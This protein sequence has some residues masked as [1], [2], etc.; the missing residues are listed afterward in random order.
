MGAADPLARIHQ[1]LRE[2]AEEEALREIMHLRATVLHAVR[3][4]IDGPLMET[5][6][7]R[8]GEWTPQARQAIRLILEPPALSDLPAWLIDREYETAYRR[9]LGVL[10]A[11]EIEAVEG[12]KGSR[13]RS[14]TDARAL[15]ERR[16]LAMASYQD[17]KSAGLC[18]I[19]GCLESV[20]TGRHG[21]TVVRCR[22]H[23]D[24]RLRRARESRRKRG[25]GVA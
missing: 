10:E 7:G 21:Q 1:H 16:R 11:D 25:E 8:L 4:L 15:E 18:T 2:R 13:V 5:Q 9:A 23:H 6:H 12:E 14:L 24:E 17:K 19:P 20:A 3:R 22:R